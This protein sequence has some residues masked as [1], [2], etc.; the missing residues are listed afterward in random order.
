M[1]FQGVKLE[2]IIPTKSTGNENIHLIQSSHLF[3]YLEKKAQAQA[4]MQ[5]KDSED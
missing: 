1:F 2:S 3:V 4:G 5:L